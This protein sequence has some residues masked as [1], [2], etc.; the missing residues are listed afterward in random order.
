M[1]SVTCFVG[2]VRSE[3]AQRI[4]A[5]HGYRPVLEKVVDEKRFPTPKGLFT[6]ADLGGWDK[7]ND[8]FFDEENGFVTKVQQQN[9]ISTE[10]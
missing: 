8:T 5:K 2:F 6:I 1:D 4:F 7:A 3:E 9:G 10:K